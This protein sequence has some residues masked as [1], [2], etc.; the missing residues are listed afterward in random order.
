MKRIAFIDDDKEFEIPLFKEAFSNDF[1]ILAAT[2]FI[3]LQDMISNRKGWIPE[4]FVLDLYF[5]SD[6]PD[7]DTIERLKTSPFQV[8]NDKAEMR[9]AYMNYREANSR[10]QAVLN[11]WKQS[12]DGGLELVKPI[13]KKYPKIPI[14]FYSRKATAEDV[15]R[16]MKEDGV[17]D[18]ISK[19]TGLSDYDTKKLTISSKHIIVSRFNKIIETSNNESWFK[20]KDAVKIVLKGIKYFAKLNYEMNNG[21]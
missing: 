8:V 3:L 14:V 7:K 20:V 1:D 18:V 17:F 21:T 19:P 13:R 4:L 6:L 11:A 9:Q 2:D 16:C 12:S 10:L 5:P 15:L